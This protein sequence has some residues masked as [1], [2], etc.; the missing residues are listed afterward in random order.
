VT[1]YHGSP[2]ATEALVGLAPPNETPSSPKLKHETLQISG[3]FVN[4]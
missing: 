1:G 2:V 3:V 4:F